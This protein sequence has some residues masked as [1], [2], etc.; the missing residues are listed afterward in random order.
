MNCK[1]L[2]IWIVIVMTCIKVVSWR[3]REKPWKMSVT[4]V[5]KLQVQRITITV[6]CSLF[7]LSVLVILAADGFHFRWDKGHAKWGILWF[8]QS[9]PLNIVHISLCNIGLTKAVNTRNVLFWR[10]SLSCA[11][12]GRT[13][14]VMLSPSVEFHVPTCCSPSYESSRMSNTMLV[15]KPSL[16]NW[17]IPVSPRSKLCP[18][19]WVV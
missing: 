2:W 13:A 16:S 10:L 17:I 7:I 12:V 4:V 11:E 14:R 18:C 15:R 9:V 1:L 8:Y 19:W 6:M 5:G 3:D